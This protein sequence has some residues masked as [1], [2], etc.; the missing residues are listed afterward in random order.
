MEV[1]VC[2][3]IISLWWILSLTIFLPF[4]ILLILSKTLRDKWFTFI[5]TKCENPMN[6][7]EFSR[8]RKKL[9]KL[10][11]ESLPNQR[12]VVPL[13]VLEIGIGEGANLQFYPENSTLTALDMNPYFIQH[14]NKNRKNYPQ[15][16][17][18]GVVVNYAEDMKEVPSDAFDVV[19]CTHVL[20]S[21]KSIHSV[22]KEVKRVLKPTGK[23]LFIEHIVFPKSK[24]ERLVQQFATPL[25]AIYFNGCYL[26]RDIPQTVKKAGFRDVHCDVSYLPFLPLFI[27][28][29]CFGIATK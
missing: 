29:Q 20:C 24:V 16:N 10:L 25:W 26:N 17:L 8:M 12:K 19:V 9:F 5:F 14:F 28:L 11:E 4:V 1:I 3:A 7:P 6:S 21:V 2:I 18:D 23:F 13:K 27:R 15:V 22:M